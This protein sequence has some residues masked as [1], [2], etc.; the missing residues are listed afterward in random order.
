[1]QLRYGFN[2]IDGWWHLSTGNYR[3]ELTRRIRLMDTAVIRIFVFDQPVPHPLKDWPGFV[4]Y[5]QGVLDAGAKPMLTFAK[6]P[7]PYDNDHHIKIFAAR[8]REVVW[9]CVE[10][11]GGDVV[12]DWY[13]CVWNE[14]NNLIIGGDLTYEMY[15]RIYEE[16]ALSI[17]EVLR[18]HLN[19]AKA[20][21]GGPAID[22]THRSY[23]MDWIVRLVSY[24]DNDLIG[25]VSWHRYGDW[26]PAV[27]SETLDLEMWGAPDPPNGEMLEDLLMAQ[28][29]S[30]EARARGVARLLQNRDIL[31]VCG[32]LNTIAHHEHYYTLGVNQN[33]LGGA[34]YASALIH[35]IRGG[36][37]LE[38]RWTAIGHGDAYGLLSIQ[39]EP[40]VAA[41]IK[42]IFVQHVRYG[43]EVCFFAH[44]QE[45][46]TVDGLIA[47]GE[48]GRISGVFVN[49][50]RLKE[51][52]YIEDWDEALQACTDMIKVD[53]G[54]GERVVRAPFDG[55]FELD[56][57]GVAIISTD[58]AGTVI[59]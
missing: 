30:Y 53:N 47:Y 28:T 1:M 37:E 51:T 57:Y 14:P 40:T 27:P 2:E 42:Q 36:A 55:Y 59:D 23:W 6:F 32:E 54:T 25:F 11:W 16:V 48:N 31:N 7:P 13:W 19:G 5:I 56:G 33:L 18:P 29:P 20:M 34:F 12:K 41:L 46:P 24:V 21:I 52:I 17:H 9:G 43:D 10:Q 39:G 38:M 8:C 58:M 4:A 50:S 26:R 3:D 35:L 49:T 45:K 15:Q 22:G 44:R